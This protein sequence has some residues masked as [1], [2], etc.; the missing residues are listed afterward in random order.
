[1]STIVFVHAHPDDEATATAGSMIRAAREGHRV[2]VVYCT[3]GDPGEHGDGDVPDDLAPGETVAM[4]RRG[5]AEASAAITGTARVAWLG[6]A[7]SG[8]TGWTQN[9]TDGVFSRA[10][11]EQAARRLAGILDEEGADVVVGYDWHGGYG[12]PDHVMLHHTTRAAAELAVKRPRYLEV[13]MNRDLMRQLFVLAAEMGLTGENNTDGFNP[14]APGDDGNPIGTPEAE[15]HWAVDLGDD[16][17][18]KREALACHASQ[19][20]VRQLLALPVEAFPFAFGTEHYI[21]PGRPPG[22]VRGWWLDA[23]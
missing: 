8:M 4:R 17:T 18:A 6:Y 15:L 2:V 19:S 23:D 20:D 5:E 1:M 14:D 16:V 22:M 12:H 7:D 21:E 3:D 9:G 13:T 11:V 10:P